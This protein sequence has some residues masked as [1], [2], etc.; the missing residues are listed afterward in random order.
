MASSAPPTAAGP[1]GKYAIPFA[2]RGYLS[3]YDKNGRGVI[4][5]LYN[6]SETL[7]LRYP[8]I[9]FG[10]LRGKEEVKLAGLTCYQFA[11][12]RNDSGSYPLGLL[13]IHW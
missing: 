11:A 9:G 6:A 10:G 12:H 4:G 2:A 8:G 13:V 3:A 5:P 7:D 1:V